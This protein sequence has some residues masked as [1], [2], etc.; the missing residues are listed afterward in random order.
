MIPDR[1]L[2]ALERVGSPYS[3]GIMTREKAEAAINV[4]PTTI[5]WLLVPVPSC[6]CC[7]EPAWENLRCTKHQDRNPCIVEG[8]QKTCAAGGYLRDDAMLCAE[9]WRAYVPPGGPSRKGFNRL[10]R[11]AR[12]LGYRRHDRWPDELQ[13]LRWRLWCRVVRR[14]RQGPP[15]GHID[16]KA[17]EKM[18]GWDEE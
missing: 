2:V 9:H 3:Y 16:Q 13:E 15:E 14:V 5:E 10:G 17:I 8:C 1:D 11:R 18:F 6:R 7:G 12:K 4:R